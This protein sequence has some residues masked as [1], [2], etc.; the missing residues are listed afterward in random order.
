MYVVS[1]IWK[2]WAKF[3]FFK[4]IYIYIY[5]HTHICTKS[6][7]TQIVRKFGEMLL[8]PVSQFHQAG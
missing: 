3:D 8:F 4:K 6:E 5:T 2:R 7:G 1:G